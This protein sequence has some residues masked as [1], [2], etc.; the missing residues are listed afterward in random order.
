MFAVGCLFEPSIV[1][2]DVFGADLGGVWVLY[3]AGG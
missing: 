3:I 2:I 1:L